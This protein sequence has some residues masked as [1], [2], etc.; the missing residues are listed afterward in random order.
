MLDAFVVACF[1]EGNQQK[2]ELINFF[3]Q[4]DKSF[5]NIINRSL[6]FYN[7]CVTPS[8]ILSSSLDLLDLVHVYGDNLVSEMLFYSTNVMKVS[9]WSAAIDMQRL[10]D[11]CL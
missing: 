8:P 6:R 4:N 1:Q 3:I 2:F 5:A 10:F 11:A 9:T 7:L